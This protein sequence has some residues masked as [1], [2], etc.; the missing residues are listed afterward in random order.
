[1]K[2]DNDHVVLL[3][4]KLTN[5]QGETL[6]SSEG[7]E[8]LAYLHGA[9]GIIPGLEKELSGKAVGDKFVVVIKPEDAYG[10][11]QAELIEEVPREMFGE[12]ENIEPGMQF[13]AGDPNGQTHVITIKAVTETTVTVD[14]NHPLAGQVLHFD[15][16]VENIRPATAEEVEHGHPH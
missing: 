7:N 4:Y 14:G 2:I 10:E 9:K 16:S 5:D 12:I 13:Q 11:I 8:P 3:H 15:V 6:D 1:M